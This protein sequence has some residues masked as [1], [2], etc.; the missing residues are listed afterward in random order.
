MGGIWGGFK[1]TFGARGIGAA[2]GVVVILAVIYAFIPQAAPAN[3][4]NTIRGKVG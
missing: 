2:L 1:G 4:G 3:L